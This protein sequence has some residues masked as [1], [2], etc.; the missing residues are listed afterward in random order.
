MPEWIQRHLPDGWTTAQLLW[1]SG[2]FIVVSLIGSLLLVGWVILRLPPDY[3]VGEH[4]P[5]RGIRRHPLIHWP[6]VVLKNIA[7]LILIALGVVMSLPGVPGQGLL[8]IFIGFMMLDFPGRRRCEK[9][10]LSRRGV[11]PSLNRVRARWGRD[12]LRLENE[13][14]CQTSPPS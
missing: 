5:N 4:P 8:T 1:I 11:L 9:W 7:G 14:D 6:L 13:P 3:F 10:F 12:S 2:I